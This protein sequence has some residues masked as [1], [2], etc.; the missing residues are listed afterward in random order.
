MYA[1]GAYPEEDR[2]T[3]IDGFPDGMKA[4]L[5]G[6]HDNLDFNNYYMEIKRPKQTINV[7]VKINQQ[8]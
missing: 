2:D 6:Y 7:L 4:R 5:P 8:T 3:K 1:F